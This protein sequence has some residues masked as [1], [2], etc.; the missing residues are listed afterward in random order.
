MTNC[1]KTSNNKYFQAPPRMADGR[2]F[3]DY[4]PNFETNNNIETDNDVPTSHDYRMFL[5]TNAEKIMELNKKHTYIK[6][7]VF[8]CIKPNQIGTMLPEK[9]KVKCNL[10]K[11]EV[12]HNYDNGIGQGRMYNTK[13]NACLEPLKSAPLELQKNQCMPLNDLVNF[14]GLEQ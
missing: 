1:Y 11:C 8:G 3:T 5:E 9:T 7:G 10:N 6:N 2:H 14:Y 13:P 4:R 12:V